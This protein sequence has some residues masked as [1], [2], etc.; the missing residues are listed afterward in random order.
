MHCEDLH[1]FLAKEALAQVTVFGSEDFQEGN[2][3]FRE[4]RTPRFVGC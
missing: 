1:S 3:T 4:K 2:R